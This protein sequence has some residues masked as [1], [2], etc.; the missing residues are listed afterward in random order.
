MKR[1]IDKSLLHPDCLLSLINT[2]YF[3]HFLGKLSLF[4]CE[5]IVNMNTCFHFRAYFK[6]IK[7]YSVPEVFHLIMYMESFLIFIVVFAAYITLSSP[8]NAILVCFQYCA[9]TDSVQIH[10]LVNTSSGNCPGASVE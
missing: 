7:Y 3:I 9:T 4:L 2:F 8:F 5:D 10:G 6:H 1:Y